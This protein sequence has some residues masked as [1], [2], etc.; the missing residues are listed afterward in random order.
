LSIKVSVPHEK[1]LILQRI[2]PSRE[3]KVNVL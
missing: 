3:K 1:N 2:N